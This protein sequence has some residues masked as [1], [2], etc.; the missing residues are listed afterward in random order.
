MITVDI[1]GDTEV[2]A[3]LSAIPNRVQQGLVRTLQRFQLDMIREVVRKLSG[4][5]LK[6]RTGVLASS[7]NLGA[8]VSRFEQSSN[9][10]TAIVG[11]NVKYGGIHEFGGHTPPHTILPKN[12]RVLAFPWKGGQAF[13]RKVEHPGSKIP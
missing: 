8:G 10:L 4:P 1:V 13:F 3:R 12:A 9:Q 6:R 11:T 2:I 5:V 7:I